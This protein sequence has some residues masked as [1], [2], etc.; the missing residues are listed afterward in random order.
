MNTKK[1]NIAIKKELKK[2]FPN[3]I[4]SVKQGAGTACGW[5]LVK[6]ITNIN[7]TGRYRGHSEIELLRYDPAVGAKFNEIEK[8]A[9]KIIKDNC[10]LYTYLTDDGIGEDREC[11]L[12]QVEG[13]V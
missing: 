9:T 3:Y 8:L 13:I 6:I 2:A 4:I 1:E 7:E 12:L 10:E 11:L 5:K